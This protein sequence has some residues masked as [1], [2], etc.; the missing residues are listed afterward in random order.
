M[1]SLGL[2]LIVACCCQFYELF[3]TYCHIFR[4]EK[5]CQTGFQLHFCICF[6]PPNTLFNFVALR[7]L[8]LR[9]VIIFTSCL[10][11]VTFLEDKSFVAIVS[12]FTFVLVANPRISSYMCSLGFVSF[13]MCC[14]QFY[15]LVPVVTYLEEKYFVKLVFSF[16][17]VLVAN[18]RIPGY[19]CSLG[20]LCIVTRY[21]MLLPLQNRKR[22]SNQFPGSLLYQFPIPE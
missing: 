2:L 16:T 3:V 11:V 21:Y 17:F 1:C 6:Q 4:R 14:Y 13:S 22:L 9:V 18:H 8:L 15:D 7:F 20:L 5:V 19:T 10:P 12:S